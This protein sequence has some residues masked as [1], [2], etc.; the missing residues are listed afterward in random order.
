MK[1]R[2]N[3]NRFALNNIIIM[4]SQSELISKLNISKSTI[5]RW[6]KRGLKCYKV[7]RKL[8]YKEI[9]V[10]EFIET[11]IDAKYV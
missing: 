5:Q 2:L 6:R 11:S 7:G 8:F 1:G 10:Y 3:H 9:E 4:I